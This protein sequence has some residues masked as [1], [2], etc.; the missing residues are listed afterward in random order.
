M[1]RIPSVWRTYLLW[2]VA[3]AGMALAQF[4]LVV[5]IQGRQYQESID[6]ALGVINGVPHWANYQS[7]I[8]GPYTVR[9]LTTFTDGNFVLA[10]V[11]FL[12]LTTLAAG[13]LFLKL[14]T[15]RFGAQAGWAAFTFFHLGFAA[16]L[17]E[18][19][20][21]A[22]DH[23]SIIVFTLFV[24]FVYAAKDWRWFAA[25][26]TIALFNRESALFIAMWMVLQPICRV[27]IE[28]G[29]E[30]RW[31]G[32]DRAMCAAGV[33]C[34]VIGL[35]IMH[36]LRQALLIHEAGRAPGIVH[37]YIIAWDRNVTDMASTLGA[38]FGMQL[39]CPAFLALTAV[40]A[41][42]L[43]RRNPARFLAMGITHIALCVSIVIF[44][45]LTETRVML[46]LLPFVIFGLLSLNTPEVTFATPEGSTLRVPES[47]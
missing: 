15:R 12:M 38:N 11:V 22:W 18:R 16:L 37:N 29:R 4:R 21:Y 17:N 27:C 46:E 24:Y 34:G 30:K 7:R 3:S 32:F 6:A 28:H 40:I 23:Y 45:V 20:L 5:L 36:L 25:L 10:H 1:S 47:G 2:I 14:A 42:V 35:F 41:F 8:L 43:V 13:L 31:Q 19:W 44:G 33:L 39:V 26:Y 9:F